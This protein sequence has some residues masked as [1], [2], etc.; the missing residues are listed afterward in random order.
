[1]STPEYSFN[2]YAAFS[3]E[4]RSAG[5]YARCLDVHAITKGHATIFDSYPLDV[6]TGR[7]KRWARAQLTE[8]RENCT[9]FHGMALE[10]YVVHLIA[11][12]GQLRPQ[13]EKHCA[14]F[15]DKVRAMRLDGALMHAGRNFALIY[16][17]GC[18]AI[19]AKI[20]PWS[21]PHLFQAIGMTSAVT[22]TR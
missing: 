10:P 15:M 6:A 7:R 14:M 3:G 19:E 8:L 4:K 13:V 1:M 22:Q 16:A 5:E 17:G 18:L 9:R 11:L 2:D 20:L 12:S 21:G